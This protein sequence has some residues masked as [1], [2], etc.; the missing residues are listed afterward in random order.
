MSR[1]RRKLS[2]DFACDK[3]EAKVQKRL[4]P[5]GHRIGLA[6]AGGLLLGLPLLI[7]IFHMTTGW[8]AAST[9]TSVLIGI[10]GVSFLPI[11]LITV[12]SEWWDGTWSLARARESGWR[13]VRLVALVVFQVH[14]LEQ[15]GRVRASVRVD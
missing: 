6:T 8:P 2:E 7:G 11:A 3:S 1:L 13:D 9:E 5:F 15:S 10:L 4:W 14:G 12:T